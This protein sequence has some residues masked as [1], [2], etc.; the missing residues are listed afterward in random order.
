MARLEGALLIIQNDRSIKHFIYLAMTEEKTK[1]NDVCTLEKDGGRCYGDFPRFYYDKNSKT[2]KE[3]TYGGC[4]GNGNNF[5]KLNDCV[6]T[7]ARKKS[8]KYLEI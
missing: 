7:C 6:N 4:E 3:F 8:L 1:S 2:C 5:E